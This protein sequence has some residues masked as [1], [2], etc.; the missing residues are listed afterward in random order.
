[1]RGPRKR[2]GFTL[3]ELLVVLA[4]LGLLYAIVGPQVI[5]Y[6]GS[7][8]SESAAVQVK[9]IDAALKLLRLDAGRYPTNE[10][11]LQALMTQ[12][13]QMPSWRGPYLPSA[14]GLTDPWQHPYHYTNPGKHGEIDVYTL[15]SDDAEGGTGEAK[16]IGNW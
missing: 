5:K 13:A 16:D 6:L 9:N 10:E 11:G 1:M 15:G 7:S 3:L 2:N 12:P 14:S 8:K 4:I